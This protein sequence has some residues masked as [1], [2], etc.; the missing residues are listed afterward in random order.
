MKSDTKFIE[1]HG[2]VL[3][4]GNETIVR[5][6]LEAGV[7]YISQYPGTP[8]SDIGESFQEIL[9]KFPEFQEYLIHP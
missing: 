5:G 1:E 6:Y 3:M 4:L 2:R 9:S 8:S 7:S